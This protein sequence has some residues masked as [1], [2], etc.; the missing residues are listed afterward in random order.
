MTNRDGAY[1][2]FSALGDHITAL[3]SKNRGIFV[4]GDRIWETAGRTL[5]VISGA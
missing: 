5:L 1:L 2:E 4:I 3:W